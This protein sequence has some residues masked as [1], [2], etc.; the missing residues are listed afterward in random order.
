MRGLGSRSGDELRDAHGFGVQHNARHAETYQEYAPNT[1][2]IMRC[3]RANNFTHMQMCDAVHA[4][5]KRSDNY[6]EHKVD[7]D[8]ISNGIPEADNPRTIAAPVASLE[9]EAPELYADLFVEDN[10][11]LKALVDNTLLEGITHQK[12]ALVMRHIDLDYIHG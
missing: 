6:D 9:K 8:F 1:W 7:D 3:C 2:A 11:G 4:F 10:E 5:S 12:V